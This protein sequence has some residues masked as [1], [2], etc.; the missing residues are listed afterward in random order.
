MDTTWY[1]VNDYY[2]TT[3]TVTP[4]LNINTNT[5]RADRPIDITF[6][7][8]DAGATQQVV[9]VSSEGDILIDGPIQNAAGS[10]NLSAPRCASSKRTRGRR[11]AARTSL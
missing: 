3:V 6:T 1:G 4:E 7:G 9:S 5:I 8:Y 11:L 2:T 10:T